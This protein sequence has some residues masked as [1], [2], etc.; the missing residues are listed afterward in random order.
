MNNSKKNPTLSLLR[1]VAVIAALIGALGSLGL[2][3]HAGRKNN[4]VLLIALFV[5]W[6]LSPF[7]ALLVANAISTRWS[8]HTRVTLYVLMLVITVGSLVSYSGVFSPPGTKPAFV[9]LVVPLLS[10][11]LMAIVIPIAASLSRRLL[12]RRDGV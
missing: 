4:S 6:V 3:L 12:R 8:F 1:T 2:M 11:L 5:I 9:F 7:I 10:W